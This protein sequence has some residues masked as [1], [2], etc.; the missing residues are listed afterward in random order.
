MK[1]KTLVNTLAFVLVSIISF[2]QSPRDEGDGYLLDSV[3][4]YYK[5]WYSI[6]VT[7]KEYYYY[8]LQ[9]QIKRKNTYRNKTGFPDPAEWYWTDKESF[10]YDDQHRLISD[11]FEVRDFDETDWTNSEK[12]EYEYNDEN[13]L[14]RKIYYRDVED[15]TLYTRWDYFYTYTYVDIP[16]PLSAK[17][18]Q[19][20]LY[21]NP[22]RENIYFNSI[23]TKS[24]RIPYQIINIRGTVIRSGKTIPGSNCINIAGLVPGNYFIKM[25][26]KD[27]VWSGRFI[28]Y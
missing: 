2:A 5:G 16:G 28:K 12:Y 23:N 4:K 7:A 20:L 9:N 22:A 13:L 25:T 26:T 21:P 24:R 14:K 3:Y 19:L 17:T 8:N 27:K 10:Y 6:E 15:T 18:D 1:M 11:I